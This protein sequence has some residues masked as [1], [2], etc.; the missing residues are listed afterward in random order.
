[1]ISL[2][3]NKFQ[4]YTPSGYKSFS[5]MRKVEKSKYIKLILSNGKEIKCSLE[6]KFIKN[7]VEIP[8]E[9]LNVGDIIDTID[10]QIISVKTKDIIDDNITLY[11]IINVENENLFIIEDNIITHNCDFSTTGNTVIDIPTLDFYKN[12]KVK[13]P[14]EMRGIDKSY[15]IWEYPDYSRSYIVCADV[16]RGDGADYSAFHV[17]DIE[18]FTQVAE[19]QGQISTKDYGNMLVTVATE[20]NNALLVVE[21]A[22]IG[23]AVLQQIIDRAYPNTFYSSADLQ[24]VDIERQISNKFNAMEK[25][26]VPGFTTTMKTR[27]LIV[28]R[29]EMYFRERSIEVRSARLVNELRTFIWNGNKP[30]ALPKYHDDLVMS[31]SIGMWVRDTA[32]K[33]RQQGVDITKSLINNINRIGNADPIYKSGNLTSQQAWEMNVGKINN[34]KKESLKWLL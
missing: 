2:K 26:M 9:H 12:E 21:N 8:A 10:N 11:D 25:K 14:I 19:Y 5:G 22:N 20:Y 34:D 23:W 18:S 24:Y 16:A 7:K 15:W 4:I 29:L 17:I 1:M 28:S 30:E 27:P 33:L 6:H 32:L 13:D 31:F 3:K